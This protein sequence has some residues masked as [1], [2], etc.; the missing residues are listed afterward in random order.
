MVHISRSPIHLESLLLHCDW[1]LI[2]TCIVL[3]MTTS[4]PEKADGLK[5]LNTAI[6]KI[7]ESIQSLGGI[8]TM[9]MAVSFMSCLTQ[10]IF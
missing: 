6:D 10:L 4:T 2:V 7:K 3:V 8:F 5:A 1:V 9:Q